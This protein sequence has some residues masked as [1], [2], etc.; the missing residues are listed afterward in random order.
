[1]LRGL[2]EN[3]PWSATLGDIVAWRRT[4]RATR[5]SAHESGPVKLSMPG[6]A[7]AVALENASGARVEHVTA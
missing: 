1:L 6:D 2:Q 3:S 4:R 5:G 7:H